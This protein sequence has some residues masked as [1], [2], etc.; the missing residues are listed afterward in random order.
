[1]PENAV[2]RF[3]A[4]RKVGSR[5]LALVVLT[6]LVAVVVGVVGLGAVASTNAQAQALSEDTVAALVA[7]GHVHQEQL[8]SRMLASYYAGSQDAGTRATYLDKMAGTDEDLDAAVAQYE[9]LGIDEQAADW[10]VFTEK[11]AEFRRIRD[12]QLVPLVDAGDMTAYQQVRDEVAQPVI[13][14]MADALDRVEEHETSQAAARAAEADRAHRAAVVGVV[15]A[16]AIGLVLA[17]GVAVWLSRML[18]GSLRAVAAT[19]DAM[20][21]GDLGHELHVRSRS[22]LGQIA[23]SLRRAQQ[24]MGQA[25]RTISGSADA[26]SSSATQ[27]SGVS[28][29]ISASAAEASGQAGAAAS[30]AGQVSSNV[31]TVAAGAEEMGVSIT[32]IAHNSAE[33]ARVAAEAVR[34]AQATNDS[35]TRLGQSSAE[36]GDV[37]KAITAIAEQTNLLA[38]N[39]TIEAARAGE[40]GKGFAV[41]A[42]EVKELAQQTGRATEDIA[43]RV[44]AIQS[45][46][47]EA[48]GAIGRIAVTI[49]RIN[50]IQTTIAAAVEEQTA[51]TA[52][53]SRSVVDAAAGAQEIAGSINGVA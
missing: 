26:L 22:E 33:A 45:D 49:E 7:R 18:V 52:E 31:Q 41:V 12:E 25:L 4:D 28:A 48:V 34:E 17:L 23:D 16:L 53:I 10:A 44:A 11:I 40:M 14:D 21:E 2:T 42:G 47:T 46:T 50:D 3:I 32:E 6:A 20:A 39:A 29:Q 9:A 37:V 51:T 1:M 24:G 5:M 27:L 36:I 35:I 13:S 19:A 15:A 30:S 38:L 8:K 43:R